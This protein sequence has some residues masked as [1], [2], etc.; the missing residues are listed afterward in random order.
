[1]VTG[2]VLA[3]ALAKSQVT[4]SS[5]YLV[6]WNCQQQTILLYLFQTIGATGW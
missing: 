5:A 3:N 6:S 4:F 2:N 1:L